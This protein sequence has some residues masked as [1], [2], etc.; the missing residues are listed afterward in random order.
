MGDSLEASGGAD[1]AVLMR[2]A[3]SSSSAAPRVDA[4]ADDEHDD[5]FHSG[6]VPPRPPADA[7][8]DAQ[9]PRSG[10]R[11]HQTTAALRDASSLAD[12]GSP[13]SMPSDSPSSSAPGSPTHPRD[14]ADI[15]V[16]ADSWLPQRHRE[17]PRGA[18]RLGDDDDQPATS[19]SPYV[20]PAPTLALGGA[21]QHRDAPWL[22]AWAASLLFVLASG[23]YG[24]LSSAPST[25]VPDN[26]G[27]SAI[28][29]LAALPLLTLLTVS[30]LL[31]AAG[32][33]AY[34]FLVR[35]SVRG[36]VVG[37]LVGAPVVLV[38]TAAWAWGGS[39]QGFGE[40]GHET[41]AERSVC[42]CCRDDL[43][44]R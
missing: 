34:L 21:S 27:A 43:I 32:A 5:P 4:D 38:L 22:V 41:E 14:G 15:H 11:I 10:W 12:D 29:V 2:S 17:P 1:D 16:S 40:P 3:P 18:V 7:I 19:A 26:I 28:A 42:V 13:P 37:A 25:G 20:Y 39:W 35:R 36:L 24:A 30:S 33:M 8:A 23:I 9:P 6:D 31:G 44:A